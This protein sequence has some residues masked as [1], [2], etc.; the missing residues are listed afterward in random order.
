[1]F[2]FTI[3]WAWIL[4]TVAMLSF[5]RG[6]ASPTSSPVPKTNHPDSVD[7][8]EQTNPK[9][10]PTAPEPMPA[11]SV[12]TY[13]EPFQSP[14]L[15]FTCRRPDYLRDTLN[16]VF[17]F[18]D[19]SLRIGSPVIVSQDGTD[20][21]VMEVIYEYRKKFASLGIP[22][23]HLKHETGHV[24]NRNAYQLLAIHYGWA[25]Q[26]VF[27]GN[28]EYEIQDGTQ[29]HLDAQRVI[30][31]EEDIHI[32]VDFFSFFAAMAPLLDNDSSLLA[33]SAFNDNGFPERVSDSRRVLR[34]DFFP[35]LGWMMTRKLWDEELA[36]KWPLGYWDDWLR[37]PDQRHGRH[38]LRPEVSRTF[39]FGAKGGASHNLFGGKLSHIALEHDAVDWTQIDTSILSENRFDEMYWTLVESATT[40]TDLTEAQEQIKNGNIRLEY[41]GI[42]HYASISGKIGLMTDEK[43]GVPRTAYKG[44]VETR[45]DG[46]HFLF[47]TPPMAEVKKAF[48][49]TA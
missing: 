16:D 41:N 21:G 3:A 19:R 48:M 10:S 38:I 46:E 6:Q 26:Q 30:I 22:L 27:S 34:S 24:R 29:Q 35:G 4:G 20:Q 18:A 11:F 36:V 45:L 17:N 8:S 23:I 25:L 28:L 1:L 31:L 32:A 39:H 40:I 49:R 42:K 33:V 2:L 9:K 7:T 37:E 5:F 12:G 13:L 14:L 47:L 44:V 15:I 43:A